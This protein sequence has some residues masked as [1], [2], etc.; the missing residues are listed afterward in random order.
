MRFK[1][2]RDASNTY[3]FEQALCSGYAP[4]GGLFVPA[5]LPSLSAEEHLIP[6]STLTFPELAFDVLRMFISPSEI[7][8]VDLKHICAQSFTPY[9]FDD[10]DYIPIKKLNSV[11]LAELFHGPTFCFKDFGMRP[12]IYL[13]SH[14]ASLRNQP[15]TL[16][17]ATTGDTGPAAVH[18]VGS[19]GNPLLTII[20]HYPENQISEFQRKQLTTV[21]SKCVK[22]ASFEGGG[23]DMDWPIKETLMANGNNDDDN[24]SGVIGEENKKRSYCGINSYNIGRPLVQMVHFIWTYLRVV[25][26]LGIT[27]GDKSEYYQCSRCGNKMKVGIT[28]Q[29]RSDAV[30]KRLHH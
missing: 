13:L 6:W 22:I 3:S 4:D 18:A 9:E 11:Y 24:N 2:T 30:P 10:D 23:D 17:V 27:P 15:T 21:D 8:D 29:C 1:S 5:L 20:V 16:L 25:E 26:Q 12:V 7:S 19:V 28:S 14:F